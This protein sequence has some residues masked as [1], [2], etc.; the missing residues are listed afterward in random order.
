MPTLEVV[1]AAE[2]V[3]TEAALAELLAKSDVDLGDEQAVLAVL[4]GHG[5][6]P[7]QVTL[8]SLGPIL[9]EAHNI[10]TWSKMMRAMAARALVLIA[11]LLGT[12]GLISSLASGPLAAEHGALTLLD[13]G[14]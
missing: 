6:R 13:G 12:I 8:R 14:W 2:P 10:R 7:W 9:A 5:I 4:A 1:N 11:L 3:S